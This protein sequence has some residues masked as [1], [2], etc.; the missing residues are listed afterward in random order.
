[1]N[2]LYLRQQPISTS[3]SSCTSKLKYT[4]TERNTIVLYLDFRIRVILKNEVHPR[5][6]IA[7]L[8]TSWVSIIINMYT[9]RF[10]QIFAWINFIPQPLILHGQF[11]C[12]SLLAN[13]LRIRLHLFNLSLCIKKTHLTSQADVPISKIPGKNQNRYH[14]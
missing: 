13:R 4:L 14:H 2:W 5:L 11:M 9:K 1:M 3:Y 8:R 10:P 7:I 6:Y 12:K